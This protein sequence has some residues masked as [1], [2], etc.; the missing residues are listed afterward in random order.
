MSQRLQNIDKQRVADL[1]VLLVLAGMTTLYCY[2]AVRASTHI[3]N[4]IMVVPVT[5]A[6]LVLCVAQFI[7][8]KR[9]TVA[10]V[11]T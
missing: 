6:V 1:L 11:A 3:Y 10:A 4:L 9:N 5:V 2:D 8:G 7:V